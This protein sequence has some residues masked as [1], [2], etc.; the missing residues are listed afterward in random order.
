MV[1]ACFY[2]SIFLCY[3]GTNDLCSGWFGGE[4]CGGF[5]ARARRAQGAT[6]LSVVAR[7]CVAVGKYGSA[8]LGSLSPHGHVQYLRC[9]P[10]LQALATHGM[11]PK[12]PS[13]EALFDNAMALHLRFEATGKGDDERRL[14]EATAAM[15]ELHVSLLCFTLPRCGGSPKHENG[16]PNHDCWLARAKNVPR[17]DLSL[18]GSVDQRWYIYRIENV[19]LGVLSLLARERSFP[20]KTEIFPRGRAKCTI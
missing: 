5:A 18:F 9:P 10:L 13:F 11:T 3:W 20:M 15:L 2:N 16:E 8:R 1:E 14:E 12:H 17:D 6:R 7:T 19:H 4:K